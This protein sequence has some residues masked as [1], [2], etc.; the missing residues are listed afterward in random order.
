MVGAKI[1]LLAFLAQ[2]GVT[3][4]QISQVQTRDPSDRAGVKPLAFEN[5]TNE[6]RVRLFP[7]V[8]APGGE[9]Y[10][11]TKDIFQ[12][13]LTNPSGLKIVFGNEV[14]AEGASVDV[15]FKLQR[16][17]IDGT[18]QKAVKNLALKKYIII[19]KKQEPTLV[20]WDAKAVLLHYR[21]SFRLTPTLFTE[22]NTYLWSL[23]N[24]IPVDDYIQSVVPSEVPASWHPTALR[25]QAIAA[26]SYAIRQMIWARDYG[27]NWDVDPT[28]MFQS[29]R[30]VEV[31]RGV[32]TSAVEE[33]KGQV[34]TY[35]GGVIEASFSSHG[36]GVTCTA[37]EC[38]DRVEDVPYL[39]SKTDAIEMETQGIPVV[40]TWQ[41]CTSPELLQYYLAK[42]QVE[43]ARPPNFGVPVVVKGRSPLEACRDENFRKRVRNEI[44]QRIAVAKILPF[45]LSPARRVWTL[46]AELKSQHPIQLGRNEIRGP[47]DEPILPSLR[48]IFLGRRSHMMKIV[49]IHD[50]G[51]YEIEGHGFGHGVGM[52]Q[53]GAQFRATKY[54]QTV[55]QIL[56]F[57]YTGIEIIKLS[58]DR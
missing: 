3:T 31:E 20:S 4:L 34:M 57:Y 21:G 10:P 16:L 53:Y 56:K 33:T 17:I 13:R 9:P 7:I 35:D 22:T 32:T 58:L 43:G 14:V 8:S 46:E 25:V 11:L 18:S 5:V 37:Q 49:K 19:P 30:G 12:V 15:N 47:N 39:Q 28:T 36:G 55:E 45:D 41:A 52:S 6:V 2:A 29:Y 38:F 42:Y 24:L 23:V 48:T 1:I 26:R 54:E 40:G 27:Q 44:D 50:D 51:I